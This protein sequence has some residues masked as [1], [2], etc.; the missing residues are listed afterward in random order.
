M[1]F[2][3]CFEHHVRAVRKYQDWYNKIAKDIK[4]LLGEK[5]CMYLF[6]RLISSRIQENYTLHSV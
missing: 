2:C 6:P 3:N 5:H 1:V 4:K